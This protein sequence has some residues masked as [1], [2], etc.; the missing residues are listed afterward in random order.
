MSTTDI[1][2]ELPALSPDELESV[3]Q[4][5]GQLL[6]GRSLSASPELVAAIDEADAS[7]AKDGGMPIEE[8]RRKLG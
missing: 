3:W 2:A 1:L 4:T 8:V 6:E 5:A 7:W